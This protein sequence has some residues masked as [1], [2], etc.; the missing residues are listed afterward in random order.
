M[1]KFIYSII[2]LFAFAQLNA[3]P[4][5]APAQTESILITG[6]TAH[7]GTGEKIDNA[8]IAF[9]EG[10]ITFVG[11]AN[12]VPKK[13]YGQTIDAQGSH[14]YPGLISPNSTLTSPTRRGA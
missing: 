12:S 8:A 7:L 2:G 13:N 1:K 9:E 11:S 4:S 3:Q 5:P 10:K 6:V 14:V